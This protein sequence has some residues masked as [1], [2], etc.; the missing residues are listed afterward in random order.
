MSETDEIKKLLV[1]TI[2]TVETLAD[3]IA[4]LVDHIYRPQIDPTEAGDKYHRAHV[5]VATEAAASLRQAA[6]NILG[7]TYLTKYQG[8][9]QGSK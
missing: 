4:K 6:E 5:G 2:R 9:D 7:K 3:E 1:Q 8:E